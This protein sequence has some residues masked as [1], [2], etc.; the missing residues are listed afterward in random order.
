MRAA[1]A[2]ADANGEWRK[3]TDEEP[4]SSLDPLPRR[5]RVAFSQ[6]K[7]RVR[8]QLRCTRCHRANAQALIFRFRG[9]EPPLDTLC[10]VHQPSG[11]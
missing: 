5:R 3:R 6:T 9:K 11:L 10:P 2:W 8:T 4:A 1:E 7:E